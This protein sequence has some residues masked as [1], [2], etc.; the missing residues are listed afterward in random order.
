M[1][2][3]K[4]TLFTALAFALLMSLGTTVYAGFNYPI[5]DPIVDPDLLDRPRISLQNKKCTINKLDCEK[6]QLTSHCLFKFFL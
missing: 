2:T 5:D 4:T 3:K 1:K 6:K